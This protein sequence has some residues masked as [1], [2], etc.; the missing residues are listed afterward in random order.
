MSRCHLRQPSGSRS[1]LWAHHSRPPTECCG[2][3]GAEAATEAAGVVVVAEVGTAEVGTTA[4]GR[5][6][7]KRA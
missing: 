6:A 3:K 5:A 1:S 2:I 4:A 7:A